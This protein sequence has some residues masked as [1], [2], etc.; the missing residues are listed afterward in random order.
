VTSG[1]GCERAALRAM[2]EPGEIYLGDR[3]FG[4]DYAMLE[5][6]AEAGCGFLLRLRNNAVLRWENEDGRGDAPPGAEAHAA[7]I[8]D[9][10]PIACDAHVA[11]DARAR[12]GD[13]PAGRAWRIVRIEPPGREPVT[14]VASSEF[15]AMSAHE[16]GELYRK[17]WQVEGFFKWL[18]CLLPCRHWFAHSERGV[19][20]QIYLSLISALL[21]AEATGR[22]PGKRIMELL[23]W[24]Q[25]GVASDEELTAGLTH[26]AREAARKRQL[27]QARKQTPEKQN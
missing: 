11:R 27:A 26:H 15:D 4:E 6:L 3:Y 16:I 13:R 18:K 7:C 10:D 17:R 9:E 25:M 8:A 22:L 2:M 5:S 23:H 20:L 14:L 12:L 21:L 19:N 24:H 1:K